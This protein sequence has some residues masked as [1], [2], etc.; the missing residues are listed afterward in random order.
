MQQHSINA[1]A[2]LILMMLFIGPNLIKNLI[3]TSKANGACGQPKISQSIK[4]SVLR[5]MVGGKIVRSVQT[6]H[7]RTR[8]PMLNFINRFCLVFFIQF[9]GET[10]EEKNKHNTKR[11]THNT[12]VWPHAR[13]STLNHSEL[14]VHFITVLNSCPCKCISSG[15]K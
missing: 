15:K 1:D 4:V 2:Y 5:E 6:I 11:R 14:S 3:K 7:T 9:L 8:T 10:R 12:I 13:T